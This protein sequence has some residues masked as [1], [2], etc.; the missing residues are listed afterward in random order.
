MKEVEKESSIKTITDPNLEPFFIALDPYCFILTEKIIPD[1]KFT[2][3]GKPYDKVVGHY[4]LFISCL[5]TAAKLKANSKSYDTLKEYL[6]EYKKIV[7]TLKSIT[8]I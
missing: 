7:E 5:E 1:P 2:K 6:E 4:K 8:N 3:N